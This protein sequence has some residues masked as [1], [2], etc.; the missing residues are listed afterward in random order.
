[1]EPS[2]REYKTNSKNS[3]MKFTKYFFSRKG[4]PSLVTLALLFNV[5][6]KTLHNIVRS[7]CAVLANPAWNK[8]KTFVFFEEAFHAV[9]DTK[10]DVLVV[11]DTTG[12]RKLKL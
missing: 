6:E 8:F 3:N 9:D 5:E 7:F 4:E 2:V 12:L 10:G 11:D 1:M